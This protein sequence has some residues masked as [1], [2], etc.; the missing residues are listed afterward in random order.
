MIENKFIETLKNKNIN[1]TE[2]DILERLLDRRR[3]PRHYI[4]VKKIL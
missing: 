1:L 2:K 4:F 3:F